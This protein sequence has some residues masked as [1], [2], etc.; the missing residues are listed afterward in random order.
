MLYN[1]TNSDTYIQIFQRKFS[2]FCEKAP[3]LVSFSVSKDFVEIMNEDKSTD[4]YVESIK[5]DW[6]FSIPVKNFI[7][8]IKQTMLRE[9]WYP[10]IEQVFLEERA[11]SNE[12]QVAMAIEGIPFDSIPLTMTMKRKI[13]WLIDRCIIH[14]DFFLIKN[15]ETDDLYRY[16]LNKSSFFLKKI[17]SNKLTKEEEGKYFFDNAVLINKIEAKIEQED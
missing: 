4:R 5:F 10:I 3:F 17:K 12:E 7:Y 2:N 6:D 1:K 9:G 13:P 15:L 8:G 16:K 14:K 11:L